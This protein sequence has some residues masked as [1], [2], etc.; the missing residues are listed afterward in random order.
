MNVARA[1]GN[2]HDR[3]YIPELIKAFEE[4]NDKRVQGMIAWALGNLGGEKS[5]EALKLFLSSSEGLVKDEITSALDKF[6][7][8]HMSGNI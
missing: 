3:K 2:T 4:I 7:V 1:M 5:K 8:D 6:K